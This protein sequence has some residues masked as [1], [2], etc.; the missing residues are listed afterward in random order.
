M[1]KVSWMTVVGGLLAAS[2]TA[3][4]EDAA[5][6]GKYLAAIMDC[7][8]CHTPG[9]LLGKPDMTKALSGAD[10]GFNI[11]GL[12]T[13]YPPNLTPDD[14]TGLGRWSESEII[15]AVRTGHR[16][17]GRILAPV[18]PYHSY[19]KLIDSDARA[20]AAYLK[21]M[22]PVRN[23]VPDLLGPNDKPHTPYLAVVLP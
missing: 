13:F 4:A 5:S 10:V 21:S 22:K 8:G 11:P 6:R 20:L 17:D 18:M 14:E 1:K 2:T 7:T 3:I 9:A 15:A 19:S 12:G 23:K 16:P